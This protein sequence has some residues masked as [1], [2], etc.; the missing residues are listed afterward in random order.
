M[1]QYMFRVILD[2]IQTLL[3][4]TYINITFLIIYAILW[5]FDMRLDTRFFAVTMCM[6]NLIRSTTVHFF[7]IA[8]RCLVLYLAGQ[9]RIQ[10]TIF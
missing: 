4:H 10:V 9:R 1:I 5:S 3:S 6:L 8:I 2:C 7:T